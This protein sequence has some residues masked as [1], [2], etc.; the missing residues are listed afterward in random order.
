M[1]INSIPTGADMMT[2]DSYYR[3]RLDTDRQAHAEAELQAQGVEASDL[4]LSWRA[5]ADTLERQAWGIRPEV[6]LLMEQQASAHGRVHG[7]AAAARRQREAAAAA[8]QS[9]SEAMRHHLT[10]RFP[11]ESW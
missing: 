1:D 11:G 3:T 2:I 10:R 4:W 7:I 5:H 8:P 9:H 6:G